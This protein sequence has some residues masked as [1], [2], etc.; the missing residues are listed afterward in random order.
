MRPYVPVTEYRIPSGIARS[1]NA[2]LP[3]TKKPL[4]RPCIEGGS[5]ASLPLCGLPAMFFDAPPGGTCCQA[6]T[7]LVKLSIDRKSTRPELQ[8]LIRISSAVFC[9][10]N[11]NRISC[12][13]F[14]SYYSHLYKL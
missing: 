3:R 13:S 2:P 4:T 7:N 12:S 6:F 14:D 8:S 10:K 9:L 1:G 5:G 11:K